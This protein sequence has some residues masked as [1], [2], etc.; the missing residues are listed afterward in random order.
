[1]K[2]LLVAI[3]ISMIATVSH[4]GVCDWKDNA[5]S[6]AKDTAIGAGVG[7]AWGSAVVMTMTVAEKGKTAI[8]GAGASWKPAGYVGAAAFGAFSSV[9]KKFALIGATV[10][11]TGVAAYHGTSY[12]LGCRDEF[13]VPKIISEN[14]P[15]W[16]RRDSKSAT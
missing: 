5:V 3:M 14:I 6:A 11:G 9:T 15:S 13:T 7:A 1:M 4:A 16:M 8:A 2:N 12:V 10:A